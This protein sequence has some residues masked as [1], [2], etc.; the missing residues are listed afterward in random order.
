[1]TVGRI[2]G[3]DIDKG[4]G[5]ALATPHSRT[6]RVVL[7]AKHVVGD[8]EPSS[9]QFLTQAGRRIPIER[10]ERDEDLDVAVLHLGEDLAEGLAVGRATEEAAWQVET[11]PL[12][13]DPKL[14]GTVTTT[15][16][17]F[18]KQDGGH[19]IYVLQLQVDQNLD[20]YK[21]YSG[22]PIALK[23]P[24]DAVIGV[25]IEQLRSRLSGPIGLSV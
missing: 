21:G 25:L 13:N 9:L 6:T 5:F 7:T 8:Q 20:E 17:Q 4:S 10:V 23:S 11:Q 16:R 24:T 14:T 3:N 22:S 1:M 2:L 19:E 12:G 15:R 18:L